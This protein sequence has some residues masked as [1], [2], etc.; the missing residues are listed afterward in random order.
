M[1]QVLHEA[2]QEEV[3]RKFSGLEEYSRTLHNTPISVYSTFE[4]KPGIFTKF[5][6]KSQNQHVN[7][8]LL[9]S[10]KSN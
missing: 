3:A 1:Y 5:E 2:P 4:N 9:E 6:L 10:D 7:N 8:C